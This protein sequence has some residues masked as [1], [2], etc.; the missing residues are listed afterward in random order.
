MLKEYALD[1]SVL[2]NW[3]RFRYFISQFGVANG[4]LISQYPSKWKRLVY[5]AT[6][7]FQAVE[8]TKVEIA[9]K[10]LVLMTRVSEWTPTLSWLENVIEEHSK[11]PFHAII[12]TENSNNHACVL[13]GS[14]VDNNDELMK[15]PRSKEI[16]RS[17]TEMALCVKNLLLC[18]KEIIFIDPYF[19]R[20]SLNPH[21]RPL[22]EFLSIIS[23]DCKERG[24]S[25]KLEYHSEDNDKTIGNNTFKDECDKRL[26]YIIPKGLSLNIIRWDDGEL[27]N[28]YIL[29]DIG[30]VMFGTGLDD[31]EDGNSTDTDIVTILDEE[32]HQSLAAIYW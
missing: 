6:A 21:I 26:P 29:T 7:N 30:G 18:S 2:S 14:Q 15:A 5:A 23:E 4:R 28:R 31:N 8:R 3:D 27:H 9:L 17:A 1:P 10:N 25:I 32:T 19:F 22:R 12:A 16:R 20:L 11:R 24:S 13:I